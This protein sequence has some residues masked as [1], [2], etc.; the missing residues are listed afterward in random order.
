MLGNL[1]TY[2][3]IQQSWPESIHRM[4]DILVVISPGV[5]GCHYQQEKHFTSQTNP[6]PGP[7]PPIT[8]SV[9]STSQRSSQSAA[10][11]RLAVIENHIRNRQQARDGP[12]LLA[13]RSIPTAPQEKEKPLPA[14]SSSDLSMK[15]KRFL[16]KRVHVS[17]IP[18]VA[19]AGRGVTLDSDEE[20]MRKLLGALLSRKNKQQ[21]K[22]WVI[23]T[24]SGT[25]GVRRGSHQ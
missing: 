24:A 8:L 9:E 16:K 13:D 21:Q 12:A 18:A 5:C 10:L 19:V 4:F 25:G 23:M 1:V 22:R 6:I 11:S 2:P 7:E 17:P 15:G 3:K 14:Q 20:D